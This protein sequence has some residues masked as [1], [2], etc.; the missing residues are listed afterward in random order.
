[1]RLT[2]VAAGSITVL[3]AGLLGR[4][5]AES[6]AGLAAAA[7]AALDPNLW[8][9]DGLIMS[10]ALA[11]LGAVGLTYLAYR[12][13]RGSAGWRWPAASGLVAGLATLV[14]SELAVL[15]PLLVVPAV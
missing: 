3:L 8:M 11:T 10:E 1:M 13:L 12:A 9:N 2:M 6:R 14:R 7:I 5:L 15:V 4:L